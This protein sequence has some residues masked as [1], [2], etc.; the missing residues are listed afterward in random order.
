M[1]AFRHTATLSAVPLA[2]AALALSACGST[3]D[4]TTSASTPAGNETVATASVDGVGTVL[5]D[6]NGNA[7][8][9]PDEESN[10]MIQCTGSCEQIWKPLTASGT[11][12]ASGDVTGELGTVKRPDGTEQV[13]LD[14]APLYTF[15][16]D[17]PGQ[18][19]GDGVQDSFGG[20]DF[21]WHAITVGAPAPDQ[22]TTT[23]SSSS[24]GY[25]Y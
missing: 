24:G 18:A 1:N 16:E 11:P 17:S 3:D 5:V 12:T 10:G 20:K 25:D 21:T 22:T 13:T 9:S 8:Y 23:D 2:I 15:A 4:T 7:L 14:G 19:T 6:A